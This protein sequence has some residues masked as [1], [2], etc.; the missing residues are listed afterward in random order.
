MA[1]CA[2]L[3][4]SLPFTNANVERAFS[5][6]KVIKTDHR[7][8]LN[9]STLDDLMEINVEGPPAE[10]FSADHAVSLWWEDRPNQAPR[11]EYRKR[12]STNDDSTLDEAEP[13]AIALDAWDNWFMDSDS[14]SD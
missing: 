14:D 5:T 11:K 6:M 8:S 1:K 9:T 4:F 7:S 10:D 13:E 12:V 3:L 2:E